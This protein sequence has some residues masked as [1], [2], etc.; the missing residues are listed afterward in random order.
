MG[1]PLGVIL[2]LRGYKIAPRECLDADQLDGKA[3]N[4]GDMSHSRST[5]SFCYPATANLYNIFH[6]VCHPS[7]NRSYSQLTFDLQSDP[8]AYRLEPLIARQYSAKLKPV[9]IAYI[10]GGL[11]S[12]IDAGFSVG[13]GIANRAGAMFE[14]VRTGITTSLFMR[15]LGL[16]K[17]MEEELQSSNPEPSNRSAPDDQSLRSRSRS[18]PALSEKYRKRSSSMSA[19]ELSGAEKLRMLNKNGRVDYCLQE[20]ILENPY[21]SAFSAHMTYWQDLDV[22]AFLIREIYR[23]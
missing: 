22:A 19:G 21:L 5:I 14:S 1:S 4:F 6:K 20:G 15:G 13:S 12:V 7:M 9:P 8:V 2:L 18:D 23:E 3:A 10:K 11:K 17:Q 16:S